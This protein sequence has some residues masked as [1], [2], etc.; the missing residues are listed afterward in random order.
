MMARLLTEIRTNREEMKN[1]QAKTDA[2]Q[3]KPDANLRE[4]RVSQIL[5]K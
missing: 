4:I 1:N 5:L 3:A 2:S